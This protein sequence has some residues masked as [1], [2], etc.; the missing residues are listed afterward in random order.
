MTLEIDRDIKFEK[1][2]VKFD[3]DTFIDKLNRIYFPDKKI[4]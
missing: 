2:K 3:K 1:I 4:L